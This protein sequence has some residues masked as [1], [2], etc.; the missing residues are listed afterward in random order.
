MKTR[1]FEE[2]KSYLEDSGRDIIAIKTDDVKGAADAIFSG[3][4]P[5]DFT[6]YETAVFDCSDY[7]GQAGN[8]YKTRWAS[9]PSDFKKRNFNEKKEGEF[10]KLSKGKAF[11]YILNEYIASFK[12]VVINESK[13]LYFSIAP[14]GEFVAVKDANGEVIVCDLSASEQALFNFLCFINVCKFWQIINGVRDFNHKEPPL[15]LLN[16]FSE[17]DEGFDSVAFLKKLELNRKIII[18]DRIIPLSARERA[19]ANK[20]RKT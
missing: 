15:I 11:R 2:L 12:R 18:I 19:N 13:H 10:L 7:S 5:N 20:P 4:Y 6:K 14:Q 17:T 1:I 8:G 3:L 16:L 9:F